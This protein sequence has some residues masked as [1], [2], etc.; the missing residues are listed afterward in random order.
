[1]VDWEVCL[2]EEWIVIVEMVE[3]EKQ[4]VIVCYDEMIVG[5]ESIWDF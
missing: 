5:E 3:Q 2:S 1:M 4:A